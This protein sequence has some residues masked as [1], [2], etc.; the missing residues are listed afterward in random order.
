MSMHIV[1]TLSWKHFCTWKKFV[2]VLGLPRRCRGRGW[3][4][5]PLRPAG[6]HPRALRA[7]RGA[8]PARGLSRRYGFHATGAARAPDAHA[9]SLER[10]APFPSTTLHCRGATEYADSW[11]N[12]RG[13]IRALCM[14]SPTVWG[15]R[16]A[17]G[18]TLLYVVISQKLSTVW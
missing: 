16:Y 6:G 5:A 4:G 12:A 18:K 8:P 13:G 15:W 14:I 9:A 7:C 11:A 3:F 10:R 2:Y 17:L 1:S